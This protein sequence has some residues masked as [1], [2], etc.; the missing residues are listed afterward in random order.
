M[1][2]LILCG[3][4]IDQCVHRC[5][6]KFNVYGTNNNLTIFLQE[7]IHL[8]VTSTSEVNI[9]SCS[10]EN[11]HVIPVCVSLMSILMWGQLWLRR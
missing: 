1:N 7:L 9:V 5:H 2:L 10:Y 11:C 3:Y 8:Q 4:F 6:F